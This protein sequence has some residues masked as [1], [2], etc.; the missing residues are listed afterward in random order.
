VTNDAQAATAI[1]LG[2]GLTA[3]AVLRELGRAG[4]PVLATSDGD[5]LVSASKYCRPLP[6]AVPAHDD[7]GIEAYFSSLELERAVLFPCSDSWARAVSGFP[8]ELQQRYP[9]VSAPARLVEQFADKAAFLDL[10]ERSSVPHPRTVPVGVARDL[11][12]IDDSELAGYFLKPC[13]S[14]AF[15]ARFGVKGFRIA[16]RRQANVAIERAAKEGLSLLAQELIPGPPTNHIFL[17]GYVARDG[18]LAALLARRR[19]RMFPRDF[20]NST[21]TVSIALS[22][23]DG[24]VDSPVD[25]LRR[26]FEHVGYTGL[27]DAEYKLDERDGTYKLLEVNPR[28]WWQIG[29]WPGCG[30]PVCF[31]AYRDALGEPVQPVNGYEV[32]RRWVHEFWDLPAW[33][34]ESER[35]LNPLVSWRHCEY[36]I[37][38][39]DDTRPFVLAARRGARSLLSRARS[40]RRGQSSA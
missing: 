24:A 7:D 21:M 19:L 20:G 13:D 4:I 5:D 3:L 26:L 29:L 8:F 35:R 25:S 37:F 32:G 34:G 39:R 6:V 9:S 11:E 15:S 27:F 36:A 10:V 23:A 30:V 17:D 33:L 18:T 1:V 40:R 22:D 12:T 28:A 38:S 16:N 14:Q 2:G 31:L